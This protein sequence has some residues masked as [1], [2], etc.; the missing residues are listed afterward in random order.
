MRVEEVDLI[1]TR[2]NVDVVKPNCIRTAIRGTFNRVH[3]ASRLL[4]S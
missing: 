1:E 3:R 4:R 2:A